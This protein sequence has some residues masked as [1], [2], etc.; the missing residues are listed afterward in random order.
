LSFKENGNLANESVK[1]YLGKK[2]MKIVLVKSTEVSDSLFKKVT[3]LTA[4]YFNKFDIVTF[5]STEELDEESY[6]WQTYFDVCI[7]YREKHHLSNSDFVFFLTSRRNN[8][9][10]I[11]WTDQSLR[12]YFIQVSDWD[13]FLFSK[14]IDIE[15]PICYEII[16]CILRSQMFDTNLEI[17]ENAHVFP[18]GCIMDYCDDKTQ[19]GLKL[20]TA[21]ICFDCGERI[22]HKQ[23]SPLII[24]QALNGLEQIRSRVLYKNT[25][26]LT[27]EL[28]RVSI[29]LAYNQKVKFVDFKNEPIKIGVI[30]TAI[31][32]LYLNHPEG[33]PVSDLPLFK[34]EFFHIYGTLKGE[35]DRKTLNDRFL[36]NLMS[37]NFDTRVTN[38]KTYFEKVLGT[39]LADHY[40]IQKL[41]NS[42]YGIKLN[43]DLV[44]VE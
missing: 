30:E 22:K 21:D 3:E 44:L 27:Y 23:V 33:I 13:T 8:Q 15:H 42:N 32:C 19:M 31:Y 24:G 11:S 39:R 4:S 35:D 17:K 18:K 12:N 43:R 37:K 6:D 20:R 26:E 36:N 38:I 14:K 16:A 2:N 41:G 25:Q 29:R 5:H 28:S 9:D 7:D 34:D 1:C 40:I 10:Y